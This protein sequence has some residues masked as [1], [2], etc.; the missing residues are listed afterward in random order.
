MSQVLLGNWWFDLQIRVP[1]HLSR[2]RCF[3][4]SSSFNFK[5]T[6]DHGNLLMLTLGTNKTA[7]GGVKEPCHLKSWPSLE[8]AERSMGSDLDPGDSLSEV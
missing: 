8:A 6:C 2:S 7:Q 3:P 5:E 4:C 1:N